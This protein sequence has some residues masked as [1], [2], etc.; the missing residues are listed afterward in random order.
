MGR[1]FMFFPI[2]TLNSDF[3]ACL[4]MP[5]NNPIENAY[6]RFCK[7]LLGVQRQQRILGYSWN[8][9]ESHLWSRIHY[10]GKANGIVLLTHRMSL[11]CSLKWSQ[12]AKC[13]LDKTDIGSWSKIEVIFNMIFER[14]MDTFYDEAFRDLNRDRSK[15]RTFAK[16]KTDVGMARYL[17]HSRHIVG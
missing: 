17:T 14:L 3:W 8:E 6:M 4:K 1:Y 16:L 2:T 5:K 9:E 7:K 12:E 10:L 15:L 13:C 11:N